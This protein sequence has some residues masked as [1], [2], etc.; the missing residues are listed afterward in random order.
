[1]LGIVFNLILASLAVLALAAGLSFFL[2]EPETGYL[3]GY[4]LLFGVSVFFIC[5]GY[6]IMALMPETEYAFIPRLVTRNEK[7]AFLKR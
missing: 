3:R 2:Q 7:N 1:M 6:S 5:A 4:I